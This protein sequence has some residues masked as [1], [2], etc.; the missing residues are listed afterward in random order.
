MQRHFDIEPDFL[1]LF[2]L[3]RA[4][5]MTTL[6]RMHALWL[7][8]RYIARNNIPGDFVECGVWRGGSMMLAALALMQCGDTRRHL[9]LF[10]TYAGMSNPTEDDKL[11][12][13][14]ILN[15]IERRIEV[16]QVVFLHECFRLGHSDS[17]LIAAR[18]R[19]RYCFGLLK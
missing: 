1:K 2:E 8:T 12:H 9:W 19:R 16:R 15:S 4:D 3:C 17:P 18:A 13:R 11:H 5:T 6:E 10:D 14:L 7:A